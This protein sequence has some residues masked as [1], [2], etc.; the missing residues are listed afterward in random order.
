MDYDGDGKLDMVSGCYDPGEIYVFRGRGDGT[1]GKRETICDKNGKPILREPEQ[2]QSFESFGSWLALVDWHNRGRLDIILGG[3]DG[4]MYLRLNEG[5]RTEPKYAVKNIVIQA[6]GKDLKVQAHAT[7]VVADWDGDGRWD[8]LSGS[9][10]G[11]TYWWRNVGSATE[12]K[13]EEARTLVPPHQGV[14][15][16]EF[17][18]LTEDYR[19]GIR[20][21]VSV[22]DWDGDG[23]LDLLVGDFCTYI[24]PRVDLKPAERK[25]M[26]EIRARLATLGE[27]AKKLREPLNEK[28]KQFWATI[29]KDEVLKPETQKKIREKQKEIFDDP[30]YKKLTDESSALE[31]EMKAFLAAPAIKS[32]T[33]DKDSSHGFVWL[34]RRK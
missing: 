19:P 11:G 21:Q 22:G 34:Y 14:G 16:S 10:D 26:E 20:S 4:K 31:K 3:Y 2:T 17:L 27:E 13:F 6:G 15:Y 1:F 18:D 23:K 9:D 32:L 30:A 24:R 7:P 25:R 28:M 12:P 5:T 33:G 8:I 29:P